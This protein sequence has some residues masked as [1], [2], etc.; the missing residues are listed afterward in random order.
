[1]GA[2]SKIQ[3]TDHTFNPVRGCTKV[4]PGCLNCYAEKL[5]VNR[6]G[7]EW[8]P[9]GRRDIA[10]ESKWKEP[11]KWNRLADL[12]LQCESGCRF[13]STVAG[14]EGFCPECGDP[15]ADTVRPRVFCA[16]LADWLDERWPTEI[17]ARLLNLIEATPNLDWQLLTKRPQAWSARLHECASQSPLARRWLDG[18]APANVWVGT[19][20][21]D[22]T[23]ADERIPELLSIPARVRFLSMEPLLG[24]VDLTR[25]PWAADPVVPGAPRT[26]L[27]PTA[28]MLGSAGR[29]DIDWVIIGGESGPGARPFSVDH[30]AEIV[31]QCENAGVP[32][33]VKQLGVFPIT[34]NANLHDWPRPPCLWP[35]VKAQR[36]RASSPPTKKAA[37]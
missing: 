26:C 33:F 17:R 28:A 35:M 11:L 36:A 32:C 10:A 13:Q 2:N 6:L 31:Q 4:S 29:P 18:E 16:S 15:Q 20:V 34:S 19:S 22:Q 3:W 24:P 1:M 14:L 9:N 12:F 37:T 30:A 25:I 23:R 8:G 21:E 5:V 7:G 27:T